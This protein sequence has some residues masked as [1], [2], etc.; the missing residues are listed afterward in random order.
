MA[1]FNSYVSLPEGNFPKTFD[2]STEASLLW[3]WC[4]RLGSA[5][6]LLAAGLTT[7]WCAGWSGGDRCDVM[8]IWK[9][10]MKMVG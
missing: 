7:F 1:I 3:K 6:L 9:K 10:W 4:P 5:A 8:P 2:T